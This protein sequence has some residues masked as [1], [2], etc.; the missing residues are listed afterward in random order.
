MGLKK[1]NLSS[2][3]TNV[4]SDV[5]ENKPVTSASQALQGTIA[6]LVIQ[7]GSSEP[8]QGTNINIRGIGTFQ[9]G[10]Y[11]LILID[12]LEGSIDNINP[13]DIE[14]VSVL[15]DASSAAVYGSRPPMV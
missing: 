2:A 7:Q 13:N 1:A 14:S 4:R 5:F 3:I 8:G 6:G 9:S 10:T 11:P 12:G 15:K